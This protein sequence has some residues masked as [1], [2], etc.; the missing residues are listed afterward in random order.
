[1]KI[2]IGAFV[3]IFSGSL[4]TA[5]KFHDCGSTAKNLKI[6]V[7]GCTE[8]MTRC[9]F[10]RGSNVTLTAEFTASK[11]EVSLFIQLND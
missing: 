1:M 4:V 9:P 2:L 5:A 7:S 6:Q 3:V 10:P 11:Y 8:S